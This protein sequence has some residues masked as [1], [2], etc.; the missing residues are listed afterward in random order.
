MLSAPFYEFEVCKTYRWKT[1]TTSV[2]VRVWFQTGRGRSY[3]A[4][5]LVIGKTVWIPCLRRLWKIVRIRGILQRRAQTVET[6]RFITG[7][8]IIVQTG[9][10]GPISIELP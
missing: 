10:H 7:H 1:D 3:G 5:S 8:R 4:Q 6:V 9:G 2:G